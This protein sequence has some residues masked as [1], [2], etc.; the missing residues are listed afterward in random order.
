MAV[1]GAGKIFAKGEQP[2]ST[3]MRANSTAIGLYESIGF[4]LRTRMN[5]AVIERQA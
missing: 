5:V 4:K 2:S 3:P 1:Y